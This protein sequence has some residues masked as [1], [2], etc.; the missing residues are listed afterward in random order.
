[1]TDHAARTK[2]VVLS[3]GQTVVVKRPG[4]RKL[5]LLMREIPVLAENPDKAKEAIESMDLADQLEFVSD[6]I[7]SCT[8]LTEDQLDELELE[9]IQM[10]A[11]VVTGLINRDKRAAALNP[12]SP[13]GND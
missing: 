4:I 13:T 8:E 10:L 2:T 6:M 9:D 7:L 3:D 5:A 12:S 11:D 1:M